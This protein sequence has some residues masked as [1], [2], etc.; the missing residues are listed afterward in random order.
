M[1][2]SIPETP[3]RRAATIAGIGYLAIF[4][5]AIFANFFVRE[6]LV[7]P[8]DA[9][10]TF[11]NIAGS[12]LLFRSGILAFLVVFLLDVI[13]AWALY[14]VFKPVSWDLSLLTAWFR[15]VYTVFLGVAIIFM[16][17]VLRLVGGADFLASLE[18]A[19]LEARA[20]LSLD[21]FN[22]TWLIGLACFGI[23]LI[24]I[25]YLLWA[26]G[27][28]P[29]LLAIV[30]AIAGAAYVLDTTAN[31]MLSDYADYA[32]VFLAIVA[33]PSIAGELWFAFWLL[34]RAGKEGQA[35]GTD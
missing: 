23:H 6:G 30:L 21:A 31:V 24:M 16:L 14:I 26:S 8:G 9:A 33:I 3:P 34:L 35:V 17:D 28:A 29:R 19:Q 5:L 11:S 12:Q 2:N 13:V 15:L 22:Y 1:T 20:M 27:S 32:D 7:E 25:A 10:T 4:V 18:P